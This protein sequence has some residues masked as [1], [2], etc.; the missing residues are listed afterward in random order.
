M[1]LSGAK[2]LPNDQKQAD[3][4]CQQL[5]KRKKFDAALLQCWDLN[6]I[7]AE[8]RESL[9]EQRWSWHSLVASG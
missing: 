7:S 6:M 5:L 9:G 8:L 1:D 3:Y 2:M 4:E